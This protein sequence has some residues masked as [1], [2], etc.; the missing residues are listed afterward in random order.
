MMR[1]VQLYMLMIVRLRRVPVSRLLNCRF[2]RNYAV[3][4]SGLMKMI[5]VRSCIYYIECTIKERQIVDYFAW[6]YH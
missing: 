4:M 2:P 1:S 5:R 3:S 6:N